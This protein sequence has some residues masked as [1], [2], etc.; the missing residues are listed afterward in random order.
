MRIWAEHICAECGKKVKS[1]Q[2]VEIDGKRYCREHVITKSLRLKLFP[3]KSEAKE[4]KSVFK[5]VNTDYGFAI[6]CFLKGWRD[7]DGILSPSIVE[8][9][10]EIA[11]ENKRIDKYN[12]LLK[13]A[14]EKGERLDEKA[15]KKQALPN[16]LPKIDPLKVAKFSM[17]TTQYIS[18]CCPRIPSGCIQT[19]KAAAESMYKTHRYGLHF[20]NV[21]GISRVS[22]SSFRQN[23]NTWKLEKEGEQYLLE[24]A[25]GSRVSVAKGL[26]ETIRFKIP[27]SWNHKNV[28]IV[29][30]LDYMIE[31]KYFPIITII[32][33]K[34]NDWEAHFGVCLL[35]KNLDTKVEGRFLDIA[36]SPNENIFLTMAPS[37]HPDWVYNMGFQDVR[38]IVKQFEERRKSIQNKYRVT[39]HA[40]RRGHGR[41][42]V[43]APLDKLTEKR[44]NFQDTWNHQRTAFIVKKAI[45]SK[46][47][48]IRIED[49]CQV[50][51]IK[52]MGKWTYFDF[53]NKLEYKAKAAGLSFEKTKSES[54]EVSPIK[55]GDIYGKDLGKKGKGRK[56]G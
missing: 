50:E 25:L 30:A 52:L 48:G 1:K 18:N 26:T 28:S 41:K 42:R 22:K 2:S 56:A 40:S 14:H 47:V 43:L 12:A 29:K 53:M 11:G 4:V 15:K 38:S 51:S 44:N 33:S 6:N 24:I 8:K 45:Q 23:V 31:S 55:F 34:K 3:D 32:N 13:I 9:H 35:K 7:M 5:S 20:G 46:C 27:C 17:E 19:A 54:C 21:E 37:D 36:V 49:L 10:R 16:D 39:P